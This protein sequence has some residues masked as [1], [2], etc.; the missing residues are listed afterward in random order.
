MSGILE[1]VERRVDEARAAAQQKKIEHLEK[2]RVKQ[3]EAAAKAIKKAN[4]TSIL[5]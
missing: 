1:D 5:W 3:A 4:D 2:E